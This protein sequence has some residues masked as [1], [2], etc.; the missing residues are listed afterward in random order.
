MRSLTKD[1]NVQAAA[2]YIVNALRNKFSQTELQY[3]KEIE[4][5]RKEKAVL[6]VQRE[7]L[8]D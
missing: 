1:V 7:E 2:T 8:D 4:K 3:E 5:L 6:K